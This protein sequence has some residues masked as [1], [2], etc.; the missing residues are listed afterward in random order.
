[1]RTALAITL[2]AG[3]G[4]AG[5][6]AAAGDST[7]PLNRTV[8]SPTVA[9]QRGGHVYINYHTGERI[10]SAFG[11]PNLIA[12]RSGSWA[13][14]GNSYPDPCDPNTNTE[15]QN[16]W[17][18]PMHDEDLGDE[19]TPNAQAVLSWQNWLETPGDVEFSIISFAFT[20]FVPDPDPEGGAIPGHDMY[21]AFTEN[22]RFTNRSLALAHT[23]VAITELPGDINAGDGTLWFIT[24]DFGPDRI[25][26]G[27]TDGSTPNPQ[28]VDLDG[29]GLIDSGYIFTYNQP[30]VGE[31]DLLA[32]RFPELAGA[33][34][35][36]ADPLDTDTFPNIVTIGPAL[37]HPSGN[38]G[39][40]SNGDGI[41]DEPDCYDGPRGEW[42][43][44]PGCDDTPPF[45]LGAWD[46]L[47]LLDAVGEY[48][49]D[50]F[51]F[52]QCTDN[53]PG[54]PFNSPWQ[55]PFLVFGDGDLIQC[56][57]DLNND[58]ILDLADVTLFVTAFQSGSL[59]ADLS[60]DGI[61][62]LDDVTLFVEL[63]QGGCP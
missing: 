4:C 34:D 21:I 36:L 22:D 16:F 39:V 53:G 48:T 40:D 28:G 58:N 50:F 29:D 12:Q 44:V 31:G 30:G 1:M 47:S 8:L 59:Q 20:T 45:P 14:W 18:L 60:G 43:F 51:L 2:A 56:R 37:A 10:V 11:G 3:V 54:L 33:Y 24:A 6:Q 5:P 62:G 15:E 23:P 35:G 57:A 26:L 17:F 61:L 41:P 19:P 13:G 7:G 27:D 55:T 42:P 49:A 25:E 38:A 46:Q 32:N 52:F 63:F 9:P